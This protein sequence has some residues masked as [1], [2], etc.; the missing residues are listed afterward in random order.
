MNLDRFQTLADA[1][2]GSITRW[3]MDVQDAAFA[4]TAASP[5]EAALA[6]AAARDLDEDLDGAERLLPGAALR[7][8]IIDAAPKTRRSLRT[9]F[10]RW[11]AGV[12]VG[13]G[14]AAAT[15]AGL[16]A[17]VNLSAASAGEDA[18]LIAAVYS[19]GLLGEE[20][21]AS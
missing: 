18:L 10:Q 3:P 6:L 8:R 9:P 1:F 11:L 20:G 7:Q 17:G 12:G 14:L 2:G 19:S 5:N 21:D 13:A 16:I 4:F 15:A